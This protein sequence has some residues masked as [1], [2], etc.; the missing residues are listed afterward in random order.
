MSSQPY[1]VSVANTAHIKVQV[2]FSL[3][4]HSSPSACGFLSS[5]SPPTGSFLVDL[6][7]GHG[8]DRTCRGCFCGVFPTTRCEVLYELSNDDLILRSS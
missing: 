8:A 4:L 2:L 6:V 1:W 3:F 7:P 5:Q